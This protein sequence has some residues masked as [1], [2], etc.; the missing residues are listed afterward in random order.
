MAFPSQQPKMF[1][2]TSPSSK[3]SPKASCAS[4]P[5]PA[6]LSARWRKKWSTRTTPTNWLNSRKTERSTS[7]LPTTTRSTS[8]SPPHGSLS[9]TDGWRER[10]ATTARPSPYRSDSTRPIPARSTWPPSCGSSTMWKSSTA[11]CA[12]KR[13]PRLPIPSMQTEPSASTAHRERISSDSASEPSAR[14]STI[15]T[16][17]GC[18]TATSRVSTLPCPTTAWYCLRDSNSRRYISTP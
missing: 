4:T 1:P 15:S 2:T 9:T 12:T 14:L 18:R 10:S 7:S 11:M 6:D 16:T 8:S 5:A 3:T 13:R 17:N